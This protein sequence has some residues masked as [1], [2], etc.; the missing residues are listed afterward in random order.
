MSDV[1]LFFLLDRV[2]TLESLLNVTYQHDRSA[3]E[4]IESHL[5]FNKLLPSIDNI[6]I[7]LRVPN[8]DVT[9]LKP[10]VLGDGVLGRRDIIEVSLQQHQQWPQD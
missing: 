10:A 8:R 4:F 3:N 7:P 1:D 2:G 6:I 5:V 9:G